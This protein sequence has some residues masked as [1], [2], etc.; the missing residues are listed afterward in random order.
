MKAKL[1]FLELVVVN[2]NEE[3]Q[4]AIGIRRLQAVSS[5]ES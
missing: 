3:Q 5:T 2:S 4:S 1:A